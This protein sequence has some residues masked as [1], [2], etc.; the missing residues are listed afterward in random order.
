MFIRAACLRPYQEG[1]HQSAD[2]GKTHFDGKMPRVGELHL[3]LGQ[4]ASVR[5]NALRDIVTS[6]AVAVAALGNNVGSRGSGHIRSITQDQI[7]HVSRAGVAH[8]KIGRMCS[9]P[10]TRAGI[11]CV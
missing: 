7:E 5:F 11:A 4:I 8:A 6:Q 9:N 3:G 1:S 2:F 10:G